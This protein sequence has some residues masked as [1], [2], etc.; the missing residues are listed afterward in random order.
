LVLHKEIK[1]SHKHNLVQ[2]LVFFQIHFI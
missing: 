1:E 2:L